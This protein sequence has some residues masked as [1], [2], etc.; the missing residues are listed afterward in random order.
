MGQL[1]LECSFRRTHLSADEISVHLPLQLNLAKRS[2]AWRC[3][4]RDGFGRPFQLSARPLYRR[5][6]RTPGSQPQ[7]ADRWVALLASIPDQRTSVLSIPAAL[8]SCLMTASQHLPSR[9]G[10][11][12]FPFIYAWSLDEEP[13]IRSRR[14]RLAPT[15]APTPAASPR[16]GTRPT[17][18][19]HATRPGWSTMWAMPLPP[20]AP[21]RSTPAAS[22]RAARTSLRPARP[23]T[24]AAS[25]VR[26]AP[27]HVGRK[28]P[29]RRGHH[30]RIRRTVQT[31]ARR[32]ATAHP[33]ARASGPAGITYGQP[34]HCPVAYRS[35]TAT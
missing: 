7:R 8:S 35:T 11:T 12:I 28:S 23:V 5:L 19:T 17:P 4:G 30:R 32:P 15:R 2:E 21:G 6:R 13:R 14:S 9:F 1:A 33:P 22:R 20:T 31:R 34:T 27:W 24:R 29:F 16:S 26:R 3:P 25:R 18:A 10:I